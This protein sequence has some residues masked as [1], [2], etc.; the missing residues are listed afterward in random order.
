MGKSEKKEKKEKKDKKEKREKKKASALT[1][2]LETARLSNFEVSLRKLGAETVDDL[3]SIE[4]GDLAAAGFSLI[5][6]RR[7]LSELKENHA[8]APTKRV[9]SKLEPDEA[10]MG[11]PKAKRAKKNVEVE[12]TADDDFASPRATAPSPMISSSP[13]KVEIASESAVSAF[14]KEHHIEMRS[15]SEGTSF[16]APAPY[17]EFRQAPFWRAP[18]IRAAL[19]KAAY[20]TP[21]PIQ[22]A[23]WPVVLAGY[24]LI[25][26]AK[27]GSGKTAVSNDC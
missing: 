1:S 10:A 16:S 5:Q 2:W 17:L 23:A 27:T 12:I 14:R 8:T 21:T 26:V 24:D 19:Q 22:S 15:E 4:D 6:R 7:F 13:V 20:T 3:R 11:T 25:A 18:G 9:V